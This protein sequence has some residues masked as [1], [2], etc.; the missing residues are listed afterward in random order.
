MITACGGSILHRFITLS[1]PPNNRPDS[2]VVTWPKSDASPG[3]SSLQRPFWSPSTVQAI[4]TVLFLGWELK[5]CG[6]C[7]LLYCYRCLRTLFTSQLN[8]CPNHGLITTGLYSIVCHPSY[9]G[10]DLAGVEAAL[11]HLRLVE[12]S[13]L[14]GPA[15]LGMYKVVPIWDVGLSVAFSAPVCPY[16]KK[17]GCC[18]SDLDV[19]WKRFF[20]GCSD[21]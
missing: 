16:G 13:G 17:I 7:I 3:L 1:P 15:E 5:L 6:T 14:V 19:S 20:Q 21:A 2:G 8:I 11:F 4:T 18:V 10:A 9:T 12:C